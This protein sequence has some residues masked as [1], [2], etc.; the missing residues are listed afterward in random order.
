MRFRLSP[1]ELMAFDNRRVL[2][3][4]AGFDPDSGSRLLRGCY[5]E[6][7]EL[8]SRLRILYRAQRARQLQRI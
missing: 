3:G 4:R 6:R 2:H 8:E 7:E 5:G 1:G